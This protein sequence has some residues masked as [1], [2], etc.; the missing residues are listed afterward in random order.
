MVPSSAAGWS[1]RTTPDLYRFSGTLRTD[2][3]VQRDYLRSDAHGLVQVTLYLAYWSGG[4]SVG[5]VGS[6]TPDACWPG[7]GWVAKDVP[8]RTVA[9]DV[10]RMRPPPAQNRFFTSED[11][12]QHVWFWQLYSGRIIDVGSTRSVP[13]LIRIALRFGFR[14][15]G[16]QAF[17]RVSSNR[18]W[19][20]IAHEPFIAEFFANTRRLGLY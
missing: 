16:D 3:L 14:K 13:S 19:E 1:V 18:P 10:G 11:F 20:E 12:A 9:L 4:A 7:A 8:E 5:A 6:H 17:I 2:H 15:G